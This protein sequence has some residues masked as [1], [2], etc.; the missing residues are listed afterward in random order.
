MINIDHHQNN[1]QFGNLNLIDTTAAATGLLVFELF[2]DFNMF[3]VPIATALFTALYTD[4][5]RFSYA[6]TDSRALSAAARL[7]A[8]GANPSSVYRAVYE[9]RSIGYYKFLAVVLDKISLQSDGRLAIL[10][11]PQTL[12]HQFQLQPWEYDDLIDYPRSLQGVEIAV[13]A[14]EEDDRIRVS[15]RSK[16]DFDVS[17][18]AGVFGGG[19]HVNA[20]GASLKPPMDSALKQL[21]SCLLKELNGR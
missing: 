21:E 1:Q 14:R 12:I 18:I 3:D 11:L 4:T 6:N 10:V 9:T 13:V 20:A 8:L 16:G 2:A 15:L 5:G 7:V 19:G 17:K